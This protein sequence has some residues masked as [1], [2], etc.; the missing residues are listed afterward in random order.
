[1]PSAQPYRPIP[2][3]PTNPLNIIKKPEELK[4][5]STLDAKQVMKPGSFLSD[6]APMGH[7]ATL[8]Y[9]GSFLE[10]QKQNA[11]F[12]LTVNPETKFLVA[13]NEYTNDAEALAKELGIPRQ[14][15][16]PFQSEV[17]TI[18]DQDTSQPRFT[19]DGKTIALV[20]PDGGYRFNNDV[21][22]DRAKAV[23]TLKVETSKGRYAE[24][25]DFLVMDNGKQ[26]QTVFFGG[27]SIRGQ[28]EL[29][30]IDALF[31]QPYSGVDSVPLKHNQKL[32]HDR[33]SLSTVYAI[34]QLMS[35]N[36]AY[37]LS[38]EQMIP[39][40]S[41]R[42]GVTYNQVLDA[43]PAERLKELDPEAIKVLRSRGNHIIPTIDQEE[44][45]S[46]EY[47]VDLNI[48]PVPDG[49]G[50]FNILYSAPKDKEETQRRDGQIANLKA[51]GFT[52]F[53]E[54]PAHFNK[55]GTFTNYTNVQ[56]AISPQTGKLHVL[57]PTE[58]E[59]E[60][61]KDKTDSDKKAYEAFQKAYPAGTVFHISGHKIAH[62]E[63]VQGGLHCSMQVL[64]VIL[65]EETTASKP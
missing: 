65:Q 31:P 17:K 27:Y 9:M 48:R 7:T 28:I 47:H 53:I 23:P 15:L 34:A 61:G 5:K 38:P 29:N 45:G 52:N 21:A 62:V 16:L 4:L 44:I 19:P 1:M 42:E 51:L 50:G 60:D 59:A 3:V 10:L 36:K 56:E 40:G 37:N 8:A 46:D 14:N 30:K 39:F 20:E 43:M 18:W 63:P 33:G 64:P 35:A 41:N 58:G 13:V 49:K 32:G 26:E 24:G 54:L 57:I 11:R 6:N 25:G 2:S 55:D 12:M 22:N